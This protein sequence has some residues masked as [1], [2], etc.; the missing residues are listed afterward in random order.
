MSPFCRSKYQSKVH[1]TLQTPGTLSSTSSLIILARNEQKKPHVLKQSVVKTESVLVVVF[2]SVVAARLTMI[3]ENLIIIWENL[4]L[5]NDFYQN[6][7]FSNKKYFKKSCFLSQKTLSCHPVYFLDPRVIT[8][9]STCAFKGLKWLDL[10]NSKY[11]T[12]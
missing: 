2:M 9:N 12:Q 8:H 6:T 3:P 1:D 4:F 11:P 5:T 10:S 7:F